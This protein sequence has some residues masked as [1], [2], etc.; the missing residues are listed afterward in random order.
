MIAALASR[1]GRM[2]GWRR[3]AV[4]FVAGAATIFAFAPFSVVPVLW[5]T[6]PVLIWLLEGSKTRINAAATGWAF[7]FGHF[8][9]SIYWITSAFYVDADSFGAIAVPA[10]ASLSAALG[11]FM[12]II[13]VIAHLL[14][15]AHDD[16]MPDDRVA[17]M[18]VRIVLFAAAWTLLEWVRSWIFTGFPWNPMGAV[19]VETRTP[20]GLAMIQVTALIGTYGLTLLTVL[21]A[22]M[23]AVLGQPPRFK[24]AWMTAGAPLVLLIVIGAGGAVR[25]AT[26]ETAYVPDVKFRLVQANIPQTERARPSQWDAQLRDY[27]VLSVNDRPA[28]ITHVVWGEAAVPPTYFLNV[29]ERYRAT[30]AAAAP[31]KGYLITGADRGLPGQ[32]EWAAIYNSMYAISP[33]GEIAAYYDKSH[34]VPF[35]EYMPLR[36]LI[37]Y[38]KITGGVGDFAA[39]LGLTTL[40]VPGLPPFTPLICYEAIFSGTVTPRRS[41]LAKDGLP[42]PQWLLNLTNDAWFGMSTGP[43]QHYATARLRAVEEGL[44]L[45]RTANTGISAVIDGYGRTIGELGLGQRGVVDAALPARAGT[46]TPF[47]VLGNFIPVLLATLAGGLAL[48][49]GRR[50]NP[51]AK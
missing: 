40:Q 44:P 7:G 2:K 38:E 50:A 46:F 41:I 4:A 42:E 23:P 13:C 34:L 31:A 47:G 29:D 32:N 45:V 14:P 19:W 11:L 8:A 33:A 10:I 37:P 21:A 1:L 18:T 26:H 27:I 30:V 17:T 9:T 39:G 5:L 25:L 3:L 49:I 35:G 15:A 51:A 6:F 28:D 43:Y 36:W 48:V 22:A 12:A 16:D 24:R 20:V